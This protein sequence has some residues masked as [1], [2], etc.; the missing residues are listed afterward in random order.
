LRIA[1]ITRSLP[2]AGEVLDE[3]WLGVVVR[4]EKKS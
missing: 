3:R 1:T 2:D 4:P